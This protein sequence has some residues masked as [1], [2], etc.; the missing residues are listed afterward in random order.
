M[1]PYEKLCAAMAILQDHILAKDTTCNAEAMFPVRRFGS[2]S[3]ELAE[4]LLNDLLPLLEN[5]ER[6][7][8]ATQAS[9]N[10]PRGP[11]H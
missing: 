5:E 1:S 9:T 7:E 11:A 10:D 2:A 4:G 3:L 6:V 8:R